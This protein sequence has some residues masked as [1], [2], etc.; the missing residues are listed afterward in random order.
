MATKAY[1]AGGGNEFQSIYNGKLWKKTRAA[2]LAK[3][4][5]CEVCLSRGVATPATV[6]H[7]VQ[8]LTAENVNDPVIVYGFDNLIASCAPCHYQH[9]HTAPKIGGHFDFDEDGN[10]FQPL[11]ERIKENGKG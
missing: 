1:W 8:H 5:L 7:H 6:V 10:V 9:H 2:Y 11:L 4:P 3:H